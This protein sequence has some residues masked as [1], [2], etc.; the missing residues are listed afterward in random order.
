MNDMTRSGKLQ[1][2]AVTD[3]RVTELRFVTHGLTDEE[4]AVVTAVVLGVLDE[5]AGAASVAE[6]A[7][8][9]WVRSAHALRAPVQVGPGSWSRSA[10]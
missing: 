8:N 1:P 6:P 9:P 7:R 2:D 4:T 5:G 10:R 3:A